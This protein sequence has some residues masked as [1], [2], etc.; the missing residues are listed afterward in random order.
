MC[1]NKHLHWH[2]LSPLVCCFWTSRAE[3]ILRHK[4]HS[5]MN[6]VHKYWYN[7]EE[8]IIKVVSFPSILRLYIHV[9]S[10]LTLNVTLSI[11]RNVLAKNIH[12]L[13]IRHI[14]HQAVFCSSFNTGHLCTQLLQNA[15]SLLFLETVHSAPLVNKC[16]YLKEDLWIIHSCWILLNFPD[17]D[18]AVLLRGSTEHVAIF[19]RA[20]SLNA[21]GVCDQLL[22]HRVTVRVH[23]VDL[24]AGFS[25][26]AA[27]VTTHPDLRDFNA[28]I[29]LLLDK[30][31]W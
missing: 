25:C 4:S 22:L 11:N 3:E 20:Q 29:K 14:S 30:K 31:T 5:D 8:F 1:T 9:T 10:K 21:V 12:C 17:A 13:V 18:F 27:T 28:I 15:F 23:H 7:T 6:E 26:G 24:P 16:S 19:S 2:I